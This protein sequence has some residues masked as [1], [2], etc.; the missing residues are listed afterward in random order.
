MALSCQTKYAG[1]RKQ[2]VLHDL[3]RLRQQGVVLSKDWTLD[4]RLD[5]MLLELRQQSMAMDEQNNVA[6]MR[7]GMRLIVTGIETVS[8]RFGILD[9]EG[10]SQ[11]VS[12]DLSRH[13][14]ALT[15]I[16][17]KYWRRGVS[18]TPEVDLGLALLGSMGVHHLKRT[19][20]R[21]MMMKRGGGS[22]RY[23]HVARTP[24][25]SDDEEEPP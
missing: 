24:P 23:A 20:T 1:R 12:R 7:D 13:D 14:A 4:D 18:N 22:G 16:Y 17:R 6:M 21:Q 3:H 25:S 10:W 9:L 5:D 15:R 11:E 8:S 19:M 2:S